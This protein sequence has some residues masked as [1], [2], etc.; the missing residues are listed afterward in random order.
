MA[1][2]LVRKQGPSERWEAAPNKPQADLHPGAQT[3]ASTDPSGVWCDGWW[4]TQEHCCGKRAKG[5]V[6]CI[7]RVALRESGGRETCVATSR[8]RAPRA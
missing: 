7:E 6:S 5:K 4:E 1:S 8:A 3:T 2:H